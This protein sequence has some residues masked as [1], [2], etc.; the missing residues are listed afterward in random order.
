MKLKKILTGLLSVA[1]VFSLLPMFI[2]GVSAEDA[3]SDETLT[4]DVWDGTAATAYDSGTGTAEDPF[5]IRTAAQLAFFANCINNGTDTGEGKYYVLAG[6][7]DLNSKEWTPIGTAAH[8]FMGT[9]NGKGFT[10]FRFSIT[11]ADPQVQIHAGLFGD[12]RNATVKNVN[13]DWATIDVVGKNSSAGGI[14]STVKNSQVIAC[15]VGEH[16]SIRVTDTGVGSNT[17]AGGIVATSSNGENETTLIQYCVSAATVYAENTVSTVGA[18]GII[19]LCGGQ[20][21]VSYCINGG[22]VEVGNS[23]TINI[24][25]GGIVANM[26]SG[27]RPATVEKCANYGVVKSKHTAGG[28]VGRLNVTGNMISDSYS[29]ESVFGNLDYTGLGVG[30]CETNATL[31]GCGYYAT[32]EDPV[33]EKTGIWWAQ[34]GRG[35]R[36]PGLVATDTGETDDIKFPNTLNVMDEATMTPLLEALEADIVAGMLAS[37]IAPDVNP[38]PGPGPVDPGDDTGETTGDD[39]TDQPGNDTTDQPGA[40]TTDKA[41]TTTEKPGT[42]NTGSASTTGDTS[43]SA[44]GCKSAFIGIGSILLVSAV[45]V[46]AVRKK[47]ED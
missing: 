33:P 32:K 29:V 11:T 40:N 3:E 45:A 41:P 9:F 43:G 39:T 25:A 14:V 37:Y 21:T 30:R 23:N 2:F 24:I 12:I 15:T 46:V 13:V 47:K 16:V 27:G 10:V 36:N 18:G 7:M 34:N 28:I 42:T 20:T 4:G 31:T 22:A 35:A 38:D 8:P 6:N 1:L 44:A 17:Y 26:G 5:V 19:G